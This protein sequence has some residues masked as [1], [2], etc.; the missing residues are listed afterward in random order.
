LLALLGAAL[1]AREVDGLELFA[2]L[3]DF[4]EGLLL[5]FFEAK[6]L[7]LE[8]ADF[9]LFPLTLPLDAVFFDLDD[10]VLPL[11]TALVPVLPLEATFP[12]AD[13]ALDAVDF[14]LA[15]TLPFGAVFPFELV[16]PFDAVLPLVVELFLV[17][18]FAGL[19]LEPTALDLVLEEL[20]AL[21][22]MPLPFDDFAFKVGLE[23]FPLATFLPLLAVL[24]FAPALLFGA[25]LPFGAALPLAEVLLFDTVDLLF[26]EAVFAFNP[27]LLFAAEVFLLLESD[28]DFKPG[29]V[30]DALLVFDLVLLFTAD[31]AFDDLAFG[32]V[33]LPFEETLD[34]EPDL[35]FLFLEL[36]L[37]LKPD[38]AFDDFAL[39]AVFLLLAAD[40][41]L[42]F[43][44]ALGLLFEP[45]LPLSAPLLFTEDFAFEVFDFDTAFL[46]LVVEVFL[47]L[48]TGL[49]LSPALLFDAV[50]PLV[51]ALL[52]EA[53]LGFNA[54]LTLDVFAL[55]ATFFPLVVDDFLPFT[56]A[57]DFAPA[58][59][60]VAAL[61]FDAVLPLA[62]TLPL[63]AALVPALALPFKADFEDFEA[64]LVAFRDVALLFVAVLPL[65]L[66]SVFDAPLAFD[67][68]FFAFVADLAFDVMDLLL[69]EALGFVEVFFALALTFDAALLFTPALRPKADFDACFAPTFAAFAE[70]ALLF[71]AVLADFSSDAFALADV[72]PFSV[73][74]APAFVFKAA[75]EG[76]SFEE[77]ALALALSFVLGAALF[78]TPS[79][80]LA[81]GEIDR[82]PPLA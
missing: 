45:A 42:P 1:F 80:L 62:A 21:D 28:L 67:K 19:A 81:F 9:A 63:D 73:V 4:A 37:A 6:R 23:D 78:L 46:L 58:R 33:F 12:L 65:M 41:F 49:D 11:L 29:L 51:A 2:R 57:L 22:V 79:N 38:L 61:L 16:L 3:L 8:L 77:R 36:P 7:L 70:A 40:V 31:L 39:D 54:D 47:F 17:D 20:L 72:F 48:E 10:V 27:F 59:L 18:L 34:F 64:D 71:D 69:G 13:L 5:W 32:V 52:L 68:E 76:L 56:T 66:A 15:A 26:L 60:F 75:L 50:L 25:T 35:E 14:P 44:T 30:F 24:V 82:K 53:P 55:D 74:L 43:E